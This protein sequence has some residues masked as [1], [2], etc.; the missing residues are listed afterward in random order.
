MSKT[1]ESIKKTGAEYAKRALQNKYVQQAI[2]EIIKI[3]T[4]LLI[5]ELKMVDDSIWNTHIKHVN[6]IA[7]DNLWKISFK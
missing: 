4:R 6:N 7:I 3:E 2:R 5:K 1:F